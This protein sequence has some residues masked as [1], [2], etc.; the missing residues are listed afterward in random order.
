[1]TW[2]GSGREKAAAA[3]G[4][5]GL[6]FRGW[7]RMRGIRGDSGGGESDEGVWAAVG[8]GRI[9]RCLSHDPR[10]LILDQSEQS[11]PFDD[12]KTI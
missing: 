7:T 12:V 5:R 3:I 10:E 8:S 1:M 4:R 2:I 6:G 9:R 11:I